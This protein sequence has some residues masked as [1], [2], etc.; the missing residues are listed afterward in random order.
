M[1]GHRGDGDQDACVGAGHRGDG[2]R[3]A[4]VGAGAAASD[5]D[6]C[7][8]LVA[9]GRGGEGLPGVAGK[10]TS[11]SDG[12]ADGLA[13][14]LVPAGWGSATAV[15]AEGDVAAKALAS[16]A[17]V[18]STV[19]LRV[20]DAGDTPVGRG[21]LPVGLPV[22]AA[23]AGETLAVRATAAWCNAGREDETALR[24][25]PSAVPALSHTA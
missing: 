12:G 6:D 4:C 13:V 21:L 19:G 3:D 8:A 2:D 7:E 25:H 20:V 22:A 24:S 10:D 15:A 14:A 5:G 17:W 1:A 9:G 18:L 11:A 23:V 16:G